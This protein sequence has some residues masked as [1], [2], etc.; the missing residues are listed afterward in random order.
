MTSNRQR[1]LTALFGLDAVIR[2]VPTTA[3]DYPSPCE[4]WSARDVVDHNLFIVRMVR[5]M[6]AG[7]DAAVPRT[8]G[9]GLFPAPVE[10]FSLA[11]WLPFTTLEPGDD[12]VAVWA[13]HFT[14]L[15][16]ALDIVDPVAVRA[17]SLFGHETLDEYLAWVFFDPLV[18]TWDVATAAGL[19]PVVDEDLAREAL[20]YISEHEA[21][22][23]QPM[24]LSD[25]VPT[26]SQDALD[27]LL[28]Y[29][30]RDPDRER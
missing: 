23:R 21:T 7:Q 10:G 30:G 24:V 19:P 11:P 6:A 18:H 29:C 5:G 17:R 14:E 3:W 9:D 25:P 8:E 4:G 26:D 28:A 16:T 12:P 15:A 1:Y 13:H 22:L 20:D 2:R 27:Q